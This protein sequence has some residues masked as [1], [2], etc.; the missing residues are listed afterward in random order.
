MILISNN[1]L[2]KIKI[3]LLKRWITRKTKK[4]FN[5]ELRKDLTQERVLDLM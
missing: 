3:N 5:G 1:I 4:D 2:F